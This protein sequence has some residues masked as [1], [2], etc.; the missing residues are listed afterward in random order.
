MEQKTAP[1]V[2]RSLFGLAAGLLASVGTAGLKIHHIF[3]GESRWTV[4]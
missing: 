2:R 4:I 1:C 3:S